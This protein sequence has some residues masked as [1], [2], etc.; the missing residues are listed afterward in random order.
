[1]VFEQT[2]QCALP[3]LTKNLLKYHYSLS[4]PP[5]GMHLLRVLLARR[6]REG[7]GEQ[8]AGDD[9]PREGLHTHTPDRVHRRH[10]HSSLQVNGNYL[11]NQMNYSI[12]RRIIEIPF[13]FKNYIVVFVNPFPED[14]YR[15]SPSFIIW[16]ETDFDTL[17]GSLVLGLIFYIPNL[18]FFSRL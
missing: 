6:P 16:R 10:S 2:N 8:A 5:S 11:K 18:Q 9:G 1:M 17:R 7:H 14:I 15:I 3:P 4:L 12:S 13:N